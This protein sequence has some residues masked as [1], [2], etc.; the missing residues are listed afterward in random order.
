[1]AVS[2]LCISQYEIIVI[3]KFFDRTEEIGVLRQARE[4][5]EKAAQ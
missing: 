1:M 4:R 2:E 5:A 3:M